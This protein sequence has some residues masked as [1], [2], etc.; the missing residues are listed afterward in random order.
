MRFKIR[1]LAF[2]IAL[3]SSSLQVSA[4]MKLRSI[5]N[6]NHRLTRFRG[7]NLKFPKYKRYS[8]AGASINSLNY[9]GDLAPASDA[10]STDFEFTR[11]GFSVSFGRKYGPIYWWRI[12]FS[13]GTLRGDDFA[14]ANPYNETAKYRYVR[15]LHF[16]NR[17]SE[18]SYTLH[19]DLLENPYTYLKRS[20]WTPY[21]FV[22]IALFYHNPKTKV[23]LQ[24]VHTGLPFEN[25]GKW[26][27]L[28]PL[29]TEGQNTG[30]YNTKPYRRIQPAVPFGLGFK[31]R[32]ADRWDVAFEVGVRYLFFDYIDDVSG[33]YVDLGTFDDPMARALSDRSQENTGGA[34]AK[35]RDFAI[36]ESITTTHTYTGSDG[37]TYTVYNGYGSD[38]H[39]SNI[40]GNVDDRDIYIITTLKINRILQPYQNTRRFR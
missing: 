9:F 12:S 6:N 33:S 4:Q 13:W 34:G 24:D 28:Q 3:L 10:S 39:S 17:I 19:F 40:R 37:K 30:V 29:G 11:P 7:P 2:V 27:A 15:N 32:A 31:F 1:L 20:T 14:S 36:I 21:V 25:G 23:P 38:K 18:L 5:K 22:G 26:V 16:R 8:F 35:P